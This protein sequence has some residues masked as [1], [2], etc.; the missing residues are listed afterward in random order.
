[1]SPEISLSLNWKINDILNKNYEVKTTLHGRILHNKI[2]KT[3]LV[4]R[5]GSFPFHAHF[6]QLFIN[7]PCL[8]KLLKT[9]SAEGAAV[10]R[11]AKIINFFKTSFLPIF[12][13]FSVFSCNTYL[14]SFFFFFHLSI[15]FFRTCV[16]SHA[17]FMATFFP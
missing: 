6:R 11:P 7:M 2:I 4:N 3:R 8:E 16:G 5:W 15:Y 17:T 14:F 9:V 1:M 10:F 12:V 13:R